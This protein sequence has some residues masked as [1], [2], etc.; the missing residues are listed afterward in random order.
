MTQQGEPSIWV[1]KKKQH[2]GKN[3][4]NIP[5]KWPNRLNPAFGLKK[6][7]HHFLERVM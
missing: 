1:K 6:I 7:T 4:K 5:I 2:L 3:I